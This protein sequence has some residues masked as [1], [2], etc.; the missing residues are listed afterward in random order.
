MKARE[1]SWRNKSEKSRLMT[2][3]TYIAIRTGRLSVQTSLGS[4]LGLG[5][6]L[7]YDATGYL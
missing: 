7:R 3:R 2:V 1:K 5:T 6:Q 4:Q